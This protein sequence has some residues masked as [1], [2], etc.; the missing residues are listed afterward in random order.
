M[1][2]DVQH[3]V[4]LC[5]IDDGPYFTPVCRRCHGQMQQAAE[6]TVWRFPRLVLARIPFGPTVSGDG[7]SLQGIAVGGVAL[8]QED[9]LRLLLDG[10]QPLAQ[11]AHGLLRVGDGVEQE[12]ILFGN[13]RHKMIVLSVSHNI[14]WTQPYHTHCFVDILSEFVEGGKNLEDRAEIG[15]FRGKT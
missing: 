9:L 8:F 7:G 15:C 2:A 5:G 13:V 11:L 6:N 12:Q 1:A 10:H 4:L 14:L 3:S